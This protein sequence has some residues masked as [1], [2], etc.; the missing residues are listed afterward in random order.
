MI[1]LHT[2][3]PLTFHPLHKCDLAWYHQANFQYSAHGTN[4]VCLVT[5]KPPSLFPTLC[6]FHPWVP[7]LLRVV[8]SAYIM[9]YYHGPNFWHSLPQD[10]FGL[11]PLYCEVPSQIL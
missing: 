9:C 5:T 11:K 6:G 4:M 7:P 3:M 10:V 2:T 8:P 1:D